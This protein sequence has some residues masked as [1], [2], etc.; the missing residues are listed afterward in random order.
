LF[1][2]FQENTRSL[3]PARALVK[4]RARLRG[5]GMTLLGLSKL[6]QLPSPRTPFKF[7]YLI[8]RQY[9]DLSSIHAAFR[10]FSESMNFLR[11]FSNLASDCGI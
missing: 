11:R 7:F 4:T 1:S 8:S 2:Y 5:F 6:Y 10:E 9:F 3:T